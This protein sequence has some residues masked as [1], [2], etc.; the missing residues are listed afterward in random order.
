[1]RSDTG[2]FLRQREEA[3]Q[4]RSTARWA[5]TS[6]CRS[7]SAPGRRP[8]QS[9]RM[10]G[11]RATKRVAGRHGEPLDQQRVL[12]EQPQPL[13]ASREVGLLQCVAVAAVGQALDQPGVAAGCAATTPRRP[14]PAACRAVRW[15]WG[16]RGR[17]HRPPADARRRRSACAAARPPARVPRRRSGRRRRSACRRLTARRRAGRAWFAPSAGR[18]DRRRACRSARR[19][20]PACPPRCRR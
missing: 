16:R 12:V 9:G 14:A 8:A 20:R 5:P 19:A 13:K 7:G 1:M 4:R 6:W 17:A 15:R 18:A 10:A 3:H 2:S 11:R